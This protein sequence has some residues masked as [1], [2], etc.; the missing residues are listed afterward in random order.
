MRFGFVGRLDRFDADMARLLRRL[1]VP[2]RR[3]A[4]LVQSHANA[5][6][7]ALDRCGGVVARPTL[8]LQHRSPE[9]DAVC[10]LLALDYVCTPYAP[11]PACAAVLDTASSGTG[12]APALAPW[13]SV[14]RAALEAAPPAPSSQRSKKEKPKGFKPPE[15]PPNRFTFG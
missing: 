15:I 4:R 5:G 3:V 7:H 12:A 1:G 2:P 14:D 8:D 9:L 6:A 13:P 10:A 11:P